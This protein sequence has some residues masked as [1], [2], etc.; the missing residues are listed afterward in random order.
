MKKETLLT[1]YEVAL[2]LTELDSRPLRDALINIKKQLPLEKL[3][4]A[5]RHIKTYCLSFDLVD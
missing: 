2:I 3:K 1:A 4:A 5:G